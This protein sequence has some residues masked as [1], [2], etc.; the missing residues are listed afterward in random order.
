MRLALYKKQVLR[1]FDLKRC[2]HSPIRTCGHL[3][4]IEKPYSADG[5]F[6]SFSDRVEQM[7][8]EEYRMA[9]R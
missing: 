8:D 5:R 9:A 1:L 4:E 6:V 2:A 7:M 3:I